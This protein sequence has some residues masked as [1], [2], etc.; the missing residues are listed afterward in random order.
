MEKTAGLFVIGFLDCVAGYLTIGSRTI[1]CI[2]NIDIMPG[3]PI[4]FSCFRKPGKM[5]KPRY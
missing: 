2:D 1:F 5:L 4:K 3:F